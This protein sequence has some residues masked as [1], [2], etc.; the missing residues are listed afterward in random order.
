MGCSPLFFGLILAWTLLPCYWGGL[1]HEASPIVFINRPQF[2][3]QAP[4]DSMAQAWY[5]VHTYSG[6]ELKAKAALEQ[7]TAAARWHGELLQGLHD[8]RT[9]CEQATIAMES[10]GVA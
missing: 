2:W 6:Y 4:E 10:V 8:M 5:V 1:L 3:F 7:R 9:N